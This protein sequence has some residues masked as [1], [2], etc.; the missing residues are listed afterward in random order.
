MEYNRIV[1]R[2]VIRIIIRIDIIGFYLCL[3]DVVVF[4]LLCGL[5][6]FEKDLWVIVFVNEDVVKVLIVM[7]GNFRW[8][9]FIDE[10][11]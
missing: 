1:V 4:L 2:I 8:L 11:I 9:W 5:V 7:F 3:F 10:V 6:A